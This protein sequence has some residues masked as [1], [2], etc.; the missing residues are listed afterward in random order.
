V[1]PRT[2]SSLDPV[3]TDYVVCSFHTDD[4]YYR[5]HGKELAENLDRLGVTHAIEEI[6]KQEGQDWADICRLK[7]PFLQRICDE[8]PGSKVFWIDV[9]C[10]L[11]DLPEF[12]H[13][14]TADIIGFQRGFSHPRTIGY[15]NRTRFWEPCFWGVNATP[16]GRRMIADAAHL[17]AR[18]PIKAT[19]DYFFEEGWRANAADLTFQII[20]STCVVGRSS[21]QADRPAFFAFGSSG[22]VA[23]FKGKVVQHRSA[24]SRPPVTVRARQ[25]LTRQ[26]KRALSRLPP[27]WRR[28]ILAAADRS[29][30]TGLLV[31]GSS[32]AGRA[33]LSGG[34]RTA[35][36]RVLR[37][38]LDGDLP[39]L[40]TAT[41]TV[42]SHGIVTRDERATMEAAR[43]FAYYSGRPS[44][45]DLQLVW[46]VRPF[47]GNFGD[48]LSP[49]IVSHY[50]DR[51]IFYRA[52][53]APTLAA[54]RHLVGL[55]S[56]GR[57]VKPNSVVVGTGISSEEY[58]LDPSAEYCSVRGP[59]TGN[60][61]RASGGPTID[62][63]GDP[64]AVLSRLLPVDRGTTN[65]RTA[66]VRHHKHR[67]LPVRLPDDY[68]ELEVL[69]SDPEKI[70]Q[71]IVTLARYDQVVTSA[72][73]IMITCQSYGIPCALIVFEG[74]LDAVA[75][76]GMKYTDY[77]L[78]VGLDPISPAPVPLDLR[79]TDLEA[80]VM[81]LTI[82]E[83]KKDEV[84]D[85]L[86]RAVAAVTR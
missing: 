70:R 79:G 28:R 53:T 55:G 81:D 3:M 30:V 77:S 27:T 39:A 36:Q 32:I 11:H 7:V 47:P 42:E 35:V 76:N 59:L 73:H 41:A 69:V 33:G 72:M 71:L 18:S 67:N 48:W 58:R 45:D 26:G 51:R 57:F 80:L 25:T 9:D 24:G 16:Q 17:E 4:D 21:P 52:A 56:I 38:G 19:D 74:A 20:P 1:Q 23:E 37:S 49:L 8:N 66:F 50:T 86:R 46:W 2:L 31:P 60:H 68:D 75:G 82:S 54:G 61:L 15:S 14:S 13:A 64:A 40:E 63:F 78:G 10:R 62:S 12:V 84:E 29:G 6:P 44:T 5:R 43:S 34:D 83:S 85:A 65:G 22:N